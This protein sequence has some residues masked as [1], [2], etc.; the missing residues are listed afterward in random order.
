MSFNVALIQYRVIDSVHEFHRLRSV[1][2]VRIGLAAHLYAIDEVAALAKEPI[3][4][5]ARV[6]AS[7]RV[8]V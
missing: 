5:I 6:V 3:G 2:E 8:Y 7:D 4:V 1:G